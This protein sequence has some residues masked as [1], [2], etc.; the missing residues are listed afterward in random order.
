MFRSFARLPPKEGQTEPT[1]AAS[2]RHIG[3]EVGVDIDADH[4]VCDLVA[5]ERVV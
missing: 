2:R 3:G 1:G 5:W 4:M